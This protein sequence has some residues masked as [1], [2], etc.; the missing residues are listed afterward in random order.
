MKHV[1]IALLV[2]FGFSASTTAQ[3]QR[4]QKKPLLTVDQ[5]A[6]LS[7]KKLTLAL[8]LSAKQQEQ[9]APVIKAQMA[10]RAKM[11][12]QRALHRKNKQKPTADQMY[13]AKSK[14]LDNR[15][16]MRNSM[17]TILKKNSLYGLRKWLQ[18]GENG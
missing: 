10:E 16:A 9:I 8:D 11:R 5:R 13:A 1:I 14:M 17:K 12:Q 6:N 15:I 3:K 4:M 7:V 18:K 2:M